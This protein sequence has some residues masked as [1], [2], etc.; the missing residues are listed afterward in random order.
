MDFDKLHSDCN[1][2]CTQA[3]EENVSSMFVIK[4]MKNAIREKDFVSYWEKGKRQKEGDECEIICSLKGNSVTIVDETSMD[5][6]KRIF[7]EIFSI[8]PS[9]KPY[10]TIV[11]FKQRGG[12]VKHTPD[13]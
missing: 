1:C 2:I 13:E 4:T 9:F 3:A 8:A 7:Q 11:K 6:V 12:L 10:F 5:T